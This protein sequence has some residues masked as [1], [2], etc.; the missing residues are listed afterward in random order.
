MP[1]AKQPYG[2]IK[3]VQRLRD[4]YEK[5]REQCNFVGPIIDMNTEKVGGFEIQTYW[6]DNDTDY[7]RCIRLYNIPGTLSGDILRLRRNLPSI[8]GHLEIEGDAVR[9]IHE[10]PAHP[11]LHSVS[12]DVSGG[13]QL[14]PVIQVDPI[15]H[16]VKET[17]YKDEIYNLLK[18]QGGTCPG[19]P[20]SP[21]V[22]QL[23]GK[24]ADGKLVFG[25]FY[26]TWVPR[27]NV[28]IGNYKRWILHLIAGLQ[29]LYS[30]DIIHKD[31]CITNVLWTPNGERLI[32]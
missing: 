1:E 17:K 12:E 28:S 32:L 10:L 29:C 22:I 18:C 27:R 15:K 24:S 6:F 11:K 9:S 7:G 5:L 2:F 19:Q 16:F 31:L 21:H 3:E 14:L 13:L 30:L 4:D 26:E 20:L 25:K 8:D 23:L